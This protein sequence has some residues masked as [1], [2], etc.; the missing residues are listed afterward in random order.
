M[1]PDSD[2]LC[3]TSII[4]SIPQYA[5]ISM[6]I[7]WLRMLCVL[8]HWVICN[9]GL[10]LQNQAAL[11][12]PEKW[13]KM[14][15]LVLR[16]DRTH[17]DGSNDLDLKGTR[18]VVA[19]FRRSQFPRV[20]NLLM[21]TPMWPWWENVHGA[22]HLQGNMILIHPVVTDLRHSKVLG[23]FIAPVGTHKWSDGQMTISLHIYRPRWFQWTRFEVNPPSELLRYG[24]R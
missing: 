23:T 24:I 13:F 6:L 4:L 20:I 7:S 21:D 8:C 3:S 11:F 19:D 16:K 15:S 18:L 9:N 12:F 2:C 10:T 17:K 1:H 5:G 14:H 22:A